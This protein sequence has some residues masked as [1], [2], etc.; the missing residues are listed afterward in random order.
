MFNT[1]KINQILYNAYAKKKKQNKKEK[2]K[3]K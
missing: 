3:D 1:T 2:E